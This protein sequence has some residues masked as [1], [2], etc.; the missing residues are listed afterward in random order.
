MSIHNNTNFSL[1]NRLKSFSYALKGLKEFFKTQHNAWIEFFVA[2]VVIMA[3]FYFDVTQSEWIFL[4]FAI[5]IV[6]TAE[7]LNTAIEYL[8]DLVSPNYN[9]K[10]GKVKDLA[11]AAVLISAIAAGITGIIIFSK[12][13]IK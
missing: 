9:E 11:S 13:I 8:T 7:M 6:L 2:L 4:I 3:G 1:N 10:A 12:Y 5:A